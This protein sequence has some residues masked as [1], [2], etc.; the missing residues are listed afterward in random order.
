MIAGDLVTLVYNFLGVDLTTRFVLKVLVV[1]LVAGTVFGYYLWDLR[2]K[3]TAKQLK[4]LVLAVSLTVLASVVGGFFTAGSPLNARLRRFDERRIND[5]QI[6]QSEIINYWMQKN[7]LPSSL[8]D[9]K[10]DISGFIPPADPETGLLYIY[11]TE[12]P[13]NFKF[14]ADFNFPSEESL[15]RQKAVPYP[16]YD[17]QPYQQNWDHG[18]GESCFSREID[19]ELYKDPR[20]PKF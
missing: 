15:G 17:G 2:K 3:Y 10:N 16:Y 8:S 12:K 14:C 7:K 18:T 13:L 5:L 1:L 6:L 19:P 4:V 11:K 9:L 20:A